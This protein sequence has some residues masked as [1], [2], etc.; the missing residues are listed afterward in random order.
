MWRSVNWR[1]HLY[2]LSAQFTTFFHHLASLGNLYIP[3]YHLTTT[4]RESWL[5]QPPSGGS[6]IHS[7]QRTSVYKCSTLCLKI[8]CTWKSGITLSTKRLSL[9]RVHPNMFSTLA[10]QHTFLYTES[11]TAKAVFCVVTFRPTQG[12]RNFHSQLHHHLLTDK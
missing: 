12:E 6:S 5:L 11:Q 1:H 7:N 8:W 3:D 9:L 2:W 4:L 10:R